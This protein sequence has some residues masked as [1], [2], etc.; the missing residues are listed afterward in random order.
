M[1]GPA[2]AGARVPIRWILRLAAT[3]VALGLIAWWLPAGELWAGIRAI[4]PAA[5]PLAILAYLTLHLIGVVK[6]RGLVNAAGAALPARPTARAYYWGLFGNLF[7]P[8]IV[9]GDVVRAGVAMG[10]AASRSAVL[11]GSLVDRIQDVV[12]LGLLAGIGALLSPRALTEESRRVFVVF[13]ALLVLAAIGA[14]VTLRLF[15]ARHAPYR[16]RRILVKVRQAMRATAARP[17]ALLTAFTLGLALQA[18]LVAL[19]WQLGR[20]VGIDA[21]AYVW[22]FVWPLAK[23]AGLTPLTQGGIGVREAALAALFVPFGVPAVSAVAAGLVFAAV[24]VAGGLVAGG[25]ALALRGGGGGA[26]ARADAAARPT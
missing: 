11:L 21:P 13:A 22:L 6:W 14:L 17:G 3:A 7:L 8:S 24:L 16:A 25:I 23:I 2:G 19:N 15:P 20:L 9:G 1:T 12:G 10:A 4:P 5:W 18:G 26:T